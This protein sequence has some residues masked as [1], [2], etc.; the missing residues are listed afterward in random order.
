MITHEHI[1]AP[2]DLTETI[3]RVFQNKDAPENGYMEI[4]DGGRTLIEGALYRYAAYDP[5]EGS[6]WLNIFPGLG[7]IGGRLWEQECRVLVRIGQMGH[8]ALPTVHRGGYHA[9]DFAFISALRSEWTL[10]DEGAFDQVGKNKVACVRQFRMLA[11]ALALLHGQGLMHGNLWPE[12]VDVVEQ[13][14]GEYS[15]RLA[16]FEMSSLVANLFRQSIHTEPAKRRLTIASFLRGQGNRALACF[17]PEKLRFLRPH[18]GGD[19]VQ[20]ER[21]DVYGLGVIVW[22]LF[23]GALPTHVLRDAF[24]ENGER[25]SEGD[26]VRRYM[27]SQLRS[28]MLPVAL[29]E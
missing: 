29:S 9:D 7:K 14:A 8:S 26:E 27:S 19:M 20:T 4:E 3:R 6:L 22:Q 18:G 10:H 25:A 15:L 28:K 16:R 21:S 24:G 11:D 23:F 13:A 5:D 2:P 1:P 17:P 12:T